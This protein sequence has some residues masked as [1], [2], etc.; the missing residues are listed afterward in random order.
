MEYYIIL[1]TIVLVWN[2]VCLSRIVITDTVRLA[3]AL[4]A[5]TLIVIHSGRNIWFGA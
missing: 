5:R 2:V 4:P 3:V 1:T